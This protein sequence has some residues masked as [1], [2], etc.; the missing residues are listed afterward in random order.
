M[1][2]FFHHRQ[3]ANIQVRFLSNHPTALDNWSVVF[4]V[5]RSV[6]FKYEV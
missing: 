5:F 4:F 6:D 1:V 3:L 2:T